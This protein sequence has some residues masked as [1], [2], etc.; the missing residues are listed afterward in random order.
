MTHPSVAALTPSFGGK[1][2][3]ITGAGAGF[4]R[5]FSMAF[6]AAGAAVAATDIDFGAA[7]ET[8][9]QVKAAGGETIAL[10]C[11][12]ADEAEVKAAV[13]ATI[14]RFGGVDFLINNAGLHLTKYNQPFGQLGTAEIH[15]L[16]NVNVMGVIFCTLACR[17]S[18]GARGGGAIV[19]ISSIAGHMSPTP[20]GV[21]K[22]A[23]RGLT[24]AFAREL[25]GDGVRV[26]A[27]SPGVCL[28]ENALAD[29]PKSILDEYLGL[30][31]VKRPGAMDDIASAA[32]FLCSPA[33]SFITGET[34]MVSGGYPLNI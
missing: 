32:L 25:K 8:A 20:Y 2:V 21:S 3:F 16:M 28:S 4:G 26:N 24:M 31:Q 23:V 1:T 7:Q 22:L 33:A 27:I 30:Q 12:V 29:L 5:N 6:A 15:N 17:Q 19:N 9:E 13:D 11:D 14:A 18:M 34:L 10:R